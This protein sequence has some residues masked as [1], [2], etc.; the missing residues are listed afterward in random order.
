VVELLF[1]GG[2]CLAVEDELT[3]QHETGG[4]VSIQ[5]S[6]LGYR[7]RMRGAVCRQEA[8][9]SATANKKLHTRSCKQEAANKK[10]HTQQQRQN[11]RSRLQQEDRVRMT[12]QSNH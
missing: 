8:T 1:P 5:M 2:L 11:A 12:K 4:A 6:I 3:E 7:G 9:Y 10:L